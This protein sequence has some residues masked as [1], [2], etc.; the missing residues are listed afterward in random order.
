MKSETTMVLKSWARGLKP[1]ADLTVSQWADRY[2]ILPKGSAEPGPYRTDR[3]PFWKEIMDVLSA[4]SRVKMVYIMKA[5]QMGATEAG[6]C[7]PIGYY[8]HYDPSEILVVWAGEKMVDKNS[9]TRIDPMITS[10]PVIRDAIVKKRTLEGGNTTRLKLFP[11]GSL[12]IGNAG[13]ITDLISSP[14]RI[15]IGD[16]I[17]EWPEDLN[18]RG[19]PWTLLLKRLRTYPNSKAVAI[20]KP[21]V[22]GRSKVEAGYLAG[23]MRKFFVPC[24]H[25]GVYQI[26]M[27]T[28][29]K[30]QKNPEGGREV[31]Y[32]CPHCKN[33]IKNYH[34]ELMLKKGE[35]RPTNPNT[36]SK[37]IRSYQISSLYAPVGWTTWESLVEQWLDAQGNVNKL[38]SFINDELAETWEEKSEQQDWEVLRGRKES[39]RSGEIHEDIVMLTAGADVQENRIEVEVIGWGKRF[40][41]WSVEYHVFTADHTTNSLNDRCWEELAMLMTK[42][43]MHP[44]GEVLYLSGICIDAGYNTETVYHFCRG[45]PQDRVLAIQGSDRLKAPIS[46][47]KAVDHIG[48]KHMRNALFHYEVGSSF[49]KSELFHWLKQK[50]PE[51][52]DPYPF[53]WCHFPEDREDEYFKQLC[54]EVLQKTTPKDKRSKVKWEWVKIRERNEALDTHIYARA[55]ATGVGYES[56]GY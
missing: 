37:S 4:N 5:S 24:P 56:I 12:N 55:A 9:K 47:A 25:C 41:H 19:D 15:A 38:I 44:T 11:G 26:L 32:E 1:P 51:R 21:S 18:G 42:Q 28:Q 49:L 33:E 6:V 22:K 20:S 7:N 50:P 40:E 17:D 45:Y 53:G 48:G 54:A 14:K 3:T 16:E 30:W 34:K 13:S 10:T 35:W 36:T 52:D 27:W 31:W 43:W 8:I 29:M 23:D 39:W 2:R 46:G